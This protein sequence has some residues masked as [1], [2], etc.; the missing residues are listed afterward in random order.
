MS[1]LIA[2][3]VARQFIVNGIELGFISMPDPE[4]PDPAHDTL[5]MIERAIAEIESASHQGAYAG[6]FGPDT[7]VCR[8]YQMAQYPGQDFYHYDIEP[9]YDSVPVT[10]SELIRLAKSCSK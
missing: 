2:L 3:K 7:V 9:Y 4:T 8:R 5:P 6:A 1:S 10:L